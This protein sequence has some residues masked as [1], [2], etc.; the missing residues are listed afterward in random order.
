M[1]NNLLVSV[2]EAEPKTGTQ[3]ISVFINHSI[4]IEKI[5]HTFESVIARRDDL[6]RS[7]HILCDEHVY[8]M[9]QFHSYGNFC[10]VVQL[11]TIILFIK[12]KVARGYQASSGRFYV[13]PLMSI[14]THCPG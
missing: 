2:Y 4:R 13:F 9:T 12:A 1:V 10:L 11:T 5:S 3:N 7:N 6:I 14:H 8:I